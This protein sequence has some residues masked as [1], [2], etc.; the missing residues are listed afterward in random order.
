MEEV[1]SAFG[2]LPTNS[3]IWAL[4]PIIGYVMLPGRCG[5]DWEYQVVTASQKSQRRAFEVAVT[6][7]IVS[8]ASK[9]GWNV[10]SCRED[11][12]T[13]REAGRCELRGAACHPQPCAGF[14]DLGKAQLRSGR[15]FIKIFFMCKRMAGRSGV[16][17][18]E[19]QK[20]NG[21]G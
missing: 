21:N 20:G 6:A 1:G 10:R 8:G 18:N 3:Y 17:P 5:V 4:L 15:Q 2:Y 19:I 12:Q 11:F 9:R 7:G 14:W 16:L 13:G